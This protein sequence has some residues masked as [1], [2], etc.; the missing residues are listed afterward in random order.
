MKILKP[1]FW[2]NKSQRNG[3]F[4]LLLLVIILQIIY[5]FID[6]SNEPKSFSDNEILN[7]QAQIDSLKSVEIEKR[8]PKIYPFNPNYIADYKGAQLGMSI[9]EIDRLLLFRKQNKFINSASQFKKVT[10][11]SDS[12]LQKISPLFK[13]PDWVVK[14]NKRKR[15]SKVVDKFNAIKVSTVDLNLAT[16]EDLQTV[17][18][19]NEFLA[20]R[21]I[22]YRKRINGFTFNTQ[23]E[24]VWKLE[25]EI[26]SKIF[27]VFS[28]I[29]KPVIEKINVNTSSFKEVLSNPYIDYN[30]CKSIFEFRDEVAELQSIEE[31]KNI[32]GF[33]LDKYD[34]IVLYLKA[35]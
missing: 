24:E 5:S 22:K 33:P 34:R 8:K 15:S 4:F 27:N 10:K 25:K 6:F 11:I 16:I 9:E 13:F 12:L 28:I 20:Q 14:Q 32:Q 1:H 19:V 17:N 7:L 30:L 2:Y 29:E 18:G 23:L 35:K 21:I 3:V 26:A 31:L